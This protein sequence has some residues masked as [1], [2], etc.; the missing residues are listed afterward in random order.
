MTNFDIIVWRSQHDT[1]SAQ[2]MQY[3]IYAEGESIDSALENLEFS[4]L[5]ENAYCETYKLPLSSIGKPP[6]INFDI[7]QTKVEMEN[8]RA[9]KI[10]ELLFGRDKAKLLFVE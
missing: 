3:D 4:I 6:N 10:S 5:G 8:A 9:D 7:Y 1:Y 2:L